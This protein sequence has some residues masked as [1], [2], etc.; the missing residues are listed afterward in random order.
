M[1]KRAWCSAAYQYHTDCFSWRSD[2]CSGPLYHLLMWAASWFLCY[3][4]YAQINARTHKLTASFA[5]SW[6]RM[7]Q[8]EALSGSRSLT[9]IIIMATVATA[10]TSSSTVP[11]TDSSGINV[12]AV[13]HQHTS[14]HFPKKA[15]GK[16]KIVERAFQASWFLRWKWLHYDEANDLAFCHTCM[17]A[18]AEGKLKC[19]TLEP[20][21]ISRGFSNWKD[22][23]QFFA[24]MR[25]L[26]ATW[27]L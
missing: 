13:P 7:W 6:C 1:S 9:Q 23:T 20:S 24:S 8:S 5:C 11:H 16:T 2:R 4:T 21:L 17:K 14:F 22:A 15:F 18:H 3:L 26:V 25:N 27:K 10:A 19:K 12:P